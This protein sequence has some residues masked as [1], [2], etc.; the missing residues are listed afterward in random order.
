MLNLYVKIV[1]NSLMFY[2]II[3]H[4]QLMLVGTKFCI[5]HICS[6]FP[7]TELDLSSSG[8]SLTHHL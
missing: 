1:V 4:V 5:E 8:Y 2:D 6:I 7:Y 3:V